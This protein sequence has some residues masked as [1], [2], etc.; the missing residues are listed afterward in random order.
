MMIRADVK[1]YYCGH[2]SGQI[3]GDPQSHRP[4]WN[5]HS[6][7]GSSQR[8]QPRG[9]RLRCDRC[10]GPVYLDEIETLRPVVRPI[11]SPQPIAQP[12]PA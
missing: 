6:R 4:Y 12:I 2:V 10:G 7:A 1:C 8:V 3:E 11:E 9:Q 5:F